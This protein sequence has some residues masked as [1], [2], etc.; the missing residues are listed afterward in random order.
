MPVSNPFQVLQVQNPEL[1]LVQQRIKAALDTLCAQING[2]PAAP[3][4]SF[5]VTGK[6]GSGPI[7]IINPATAKLDGRITAGMQ[8][9]SVVSAAQDSAY[10][11]EAAISQTGNLRQLDTANLSGNTYTVTVRGK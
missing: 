7:A 10:Q 2:A 1:V 5:V 9:V 4:F 8:V 6:N 3:T 11:F